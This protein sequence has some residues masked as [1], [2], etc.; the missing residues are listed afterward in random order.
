MRVLQLIVLCAVLISSTAA[1]DFQAH[2]SIQHGVPDYGVPDYGEYYGA[3][4]EEGDA[5]NPYDG[6]APK[7][8]P[9]SCAN[10]LHEQSAKL[11]EQGEKIDGLSQ[12]LGTALTIIGDLV[13][14]LD[15]VKNE[16]D[17]F[18]GVL[19]NLLDLAT[20][21]AELADAVAS[22]E[23]GAKG[24]PGTKGAQGV[25]GAKGETGRPPSR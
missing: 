15:S 14:A 21:K 16:K 9:A 4:D 2:V 24:E 23:K 7:T 10:Q 3:S 17:D 12:Q 18:T 19:G 5:Y 1:H 25:S 13:T 8:C 6:D 22:V 11:Q 20:V